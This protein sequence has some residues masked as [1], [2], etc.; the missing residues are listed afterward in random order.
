MNARQQWKRCEERKIREGKKDRRKKGE[1][2]GRQQW[3]EE[4]ERKPLYDVNS[5]IITKRD[6]RHL[7]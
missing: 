1:M 6:V 7:K 2:N 5:F 4:E 3:K